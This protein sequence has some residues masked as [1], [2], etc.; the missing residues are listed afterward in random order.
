MT[1]INETVD[2]WLAAWTEPDETRR[3]RLIAELWAEDGALVDPPMT[4]TG[5]A[6]L[7]AITAALQAQFPA[8]TFRRTTGIDAHHDCVRYGWALVA[9]DGTSTLDGLDVAEVTADGR[10]QRVSGFFGDLPGA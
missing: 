9:P 5:H 6:E 7:T 10:L 8:H 4:A 1:D 3:G 2:T